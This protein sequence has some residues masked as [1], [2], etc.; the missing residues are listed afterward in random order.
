MTEIDLFIPQKGFALDIDDTLAMSAHFYFHAML[1]RY[2]SPE[3]LSAVEL[4]R[5]YRYLENVEYWQEDEMTE[6]LYAQ[7]WDHQKVESIPLIEDA[8]HTLQKIE[9]IV[10]ISCYLTLRR[11]KIR[12]PT[13][14][15]IK[16]HGFPD[17]PVV[18]HDN[19]TP[20]EKGHAWKAEFLVKNYPTVLGLIDDNASVIQHLPP[21]YP[22]FI[23]L[24][25]YP[26]YP[27]DTGL[28]IIPCATWDMVYEEIKKRQNVFSVS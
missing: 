13:E 27:H 7:F 4:W 25:D 21:E 2:G 14:S 18:M 24:Y 10:P 28:N 12:P 6:W 16:K 8:H 19:E 11:E 20:Y 17:R 22:G 3:S 26:E 23:F 1:E 9:Q 5:K 15:W